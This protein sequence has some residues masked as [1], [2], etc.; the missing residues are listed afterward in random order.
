MKRIAIIISVV[1]LLL[2]MAISLAVLSRHGYF[3]EHYSLSAERMEY[4][5]SVIN[6][7][8]AAD[9]FPGAVLLDCG[10]CGVPDCAAHRGDHVKIY[11]ISKKIPAF[12]RDFL[13]YGECIRI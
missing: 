7:A 10:G 6:G 12:S 13:F 5:D 8:I 1:T 2:Y 3:G 11:V 9:D 4:A